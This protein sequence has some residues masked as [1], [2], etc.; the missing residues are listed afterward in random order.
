MKVEI[1]LAPEVQAALDAGHPVV[2]L[3]STIIAH[4]MPYPENLN[5]AREVEAVVRAHA[6]TPATIAILGGKL[7]VGLGY[8]EIDNLAR[9]R[10][11]HP[12]SVCPRSSVCRFAGT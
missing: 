10:P 5:M 11:E 2:A 4:G 8:E 6:A 9:E 3:E 7:K 1:S 12:Q